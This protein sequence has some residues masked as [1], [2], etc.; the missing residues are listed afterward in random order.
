[1]NNVR[2]A[3]D[4]RFS[5]PI[6]PTDRRRNI[7]PRYLMFTSLTYPCKVIGR[8]TGSA[9]IRV[10][11]C[12]RFVLFNKSIAFRSV[13]SKLFDIDHA[14]IIFFQIKFTTVLCRDSSTKDTSHVLYSTVLLQSL[15]KKVAAQWASH[16][17]LSPAH[18]E[19]AYNIFFSAFGRLA[20]DVL[21]HQS[22]WV[23]GGVHV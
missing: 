2:A 14:P 4:Q 9:S 8:N 20:C 23:H 6:H 18:A 5:V 12:I 21:L 13:G 17:T 19:G 11:P 10:L 16:A 1:M 15:Q 22:G 7:L 3:L